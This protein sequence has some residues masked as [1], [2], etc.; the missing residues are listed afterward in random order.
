MNVT[1]WKDQ[2]W[3]TFPSVYYKIKVINKGYSICKQYL[4]KEWT[5]VL[6]VLI[7]QVIS[8]ICTEHSHTNRTSVIKIQ[9]TIIKATYRWQP[10]CDFILQ[11]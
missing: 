4:Q 8:I 1:R 10:F 3:L 9:S 11:N 5:L 2:S 6:V 7:L